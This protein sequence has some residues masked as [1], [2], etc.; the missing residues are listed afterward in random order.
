ML[1]LF[2]LL[3]HLPDLILKIWPA[4]KGELDPVAACTFEDR[5]PSAEREVA[6]HHKDTKVLYPIGQVGF[7]MN[8]VPT[9]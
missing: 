8:W 2:F 6:Q 9:S 4:L 1:V 7:F 5:R 3:K